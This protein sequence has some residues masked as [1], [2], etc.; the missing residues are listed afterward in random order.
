[1]RAF[2]PGAQGSQLAGVLI[3]RLPIPV[4][5]KASPPFPLLSDRF[6]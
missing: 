1:M 4:T 2:R 5:T 6:G 3:R